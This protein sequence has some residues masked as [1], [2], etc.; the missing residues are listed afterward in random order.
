MGRNEPG[1]A[2]RPAPFS[3]LECA[4]YCGAISSIR[5]GRLENVQTKCLSFARPAQ[6]NRRVRPPFPGEPFTP[7]RCLGKLTAFIGGL[8]K[9]L[10]PYFRSRIRHRSK[11]NRNPS[12]FNAP[13]PFSRCPP[14]LSS[15][16]PSSPS[17]DR[18]ESR[19]QKRDTSRLPPSAL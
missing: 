9:T 17:P 14:L 18:K 3:Q 5:R 19:N 7:R 4:N 13:L 2:E 15:R 10:M 11:P 8:I 1:E 6:C 12:P 16:R